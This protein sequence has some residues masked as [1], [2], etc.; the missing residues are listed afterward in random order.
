MHFWCLQI[1][2]I[3]KLGQK[4]IAFAVLHINRIYLHPVLTD[5]L[6]IAIQQRSQEE[7]EIH[8]I[9]LIDPDNFLRLEHEYELTKVEIDPDILSWM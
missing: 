6:K 2:L 1:V 8:L 4:T 7:E 5:Y 9:N 3:A